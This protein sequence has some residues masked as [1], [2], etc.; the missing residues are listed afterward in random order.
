M[1]FLCS[2]SMLPVLK[3]TSSLSLNFSLPTLTI[4]QLQICMSST[5]GR[6]TILGFAITSCLFV[7]PFCMLVL[8]Q[9]LQRWRDQH[10][11]KINSNFHLFT[12]HL[13]AIE[14]IGIF[15]C[16]I[17]FC[18]SETNFQLLMEMGN[19]LFVFTSVGQMFFHFLSSVERYLAVIHPIYYRTLTDA[20]AI[21]IRNVAIGCA[22]AMSFAIPFLSYISGPLPIVCTAF[23]VMLYFVVF[24]FLSISVVC[25]MTDKGPG[26]E[27][28][29]TESFG[30]KL[31]AFYSILVILGLTFLR[32]VGHL[33]LVIFLIFSYVGKAGPC[34][35][36]LADFWFGLPSSL[37]LPLLYLRK[38]GKLRC[39]GRHK[40][41]GKCTH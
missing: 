31:R 16:I 10:S 28:G 41:S 7:L 6:Y 21:R 29:T 36:S 23:I 3:A 12:Y 8:F 1:P 2:V 17:I 30:P 38:A 18:G 27:V 34:A 14:I 5:S 20:K 35:F 22:W 32:F 13:A 19:V 15:G 4:S 37:V 11:N 25:A 24:M 26:R 33:V 40:Q 9:G 39:C